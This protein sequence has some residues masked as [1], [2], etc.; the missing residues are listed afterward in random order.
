MKSSINL[1]FAALVLI[2]AGC[3]EGRI[4][5]DYEFEGPEGVS[6]H[7]TATVTG[8]DLW[9]EGYSLAVAGFAD[10]NEYALISKNIEVGAEGNCDI[11]LSGI[12]SGTSTIE[13]CAIDRLRRR[14]ASFAKTECADKA[15]ALSLDAGT[16]DTSPA[17][18]IQAEIFNTTCIQCHG[19]SNFSAARLNLTAG[20]ALDE[21]IGVESVKEPG[22]LRVEAGNSAASVLYRILATDESAYW[23]YDHSVEVVAPEK[24]DLI[25]NWIDAGAKH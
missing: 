11:V 4:Y 7:V 18:G 17:A 13:L 22:H 2:A 15:D 23:N 21:L 14:V 5:D 24:L 12:P 8:A 1:A 19:G 3:D 9:P 25:K 16:I 6:A 20:H 10:G